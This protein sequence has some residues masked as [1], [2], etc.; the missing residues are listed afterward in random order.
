MVKCLKLKII[1]PMDVEW[2]VFG[3]IMRQCQ[4]ET[5]NIMNKAIQ[6][7]W[8][9]EG[10]KS[11]YKSK[12]DLY[13]APKEIL[14]KSLSGFLYDRIA[15]SEGN[16]QATSNLSQALSLA[17]QKWQNDKKE[18]FIGEKS[19]ASYR[20][21]N[22]IYLKN[23]SLKLYKDNGCYIFNISL[24]NK[25]YREKEKLVSTQFAVLV[26]EGKKYSKTIL[27]RCLNGEY[28]IAGSSIVNKGKTWFINLSY[29]FDA[30][31]SELIS[32]KILGVDMGIKYAVYMAVGGGFE[33]ASID[34]G[35][36]SKYRVTVE[37]K[38]NNILRQT[39]YCGEGRIGHGRK[40][41]IRPVEKLNDRISN[42]RDTIN[43][44]YARY[45]VDFAVKNQCAVI[46]LE[47]LSGIT[48]GKKD[49]F[50]KHW[51]Y[52]DLQNKIKSKAMEKGINVISIDPK[53]TSQR[54]S[55]CG[56]IDKE[57]RPEQALFLCQSCGFKANADHNAALNIAVKD[58]DQI[59]K[60][61]II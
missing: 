32:D 43:H 47:D 48:E 46:Q 41:R 57:N 34:G 8:E 31:K 26:D 42:F 12:H 45:I 3:D 28:K 27:D 52:F 49:R 22:P 17:E 25:K 23:S 15:K 11:E 36:I 18:V 6:L 10:F 50:L 38:R 7:C 60:S 16:I 39:K 5:R 54:C 61:N 24:V 19:I 30:Q 29:N 55:R 51:T 53:Y 56:Y 59:I 20:K 13:P 33:R 40:T 35:E 4:K 14:N 58:I 9:W 21:D 37:A 2:S 1:K 44:K